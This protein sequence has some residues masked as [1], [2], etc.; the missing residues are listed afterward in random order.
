MTDKAFA[1]RPDMVAD[2]V[3]D[4]F[5]R[6]SSIVGMYEVCRIAQVGVFGLVLPEDQD[7]TF[8][9]SREGS[10]GECRAAAQAD[11]AA[12]IASALS[13]AFIERMAA[14]EAEND[15]FAA[16]NETL[17]E[18]VCDAQLVLDPSAETQW[19]KH[20]KHLTERTTL[21]ENAED[22][23]RQGDET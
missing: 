22:G 4:Q 6:A 9:F 19:W 7:N 16:E 3:W 17:L 12:R 8:P 11:Y 14:L 21:Q 2:L 10:E 20:Y 23:E 5:G 1:I 15:R 18:A 13:P